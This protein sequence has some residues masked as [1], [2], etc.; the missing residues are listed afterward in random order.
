MAFDSYGVLH[1]VWVDEGLQEEHVLYHISFDG[2]SWTATTAITSHTILSQSPSIAADDLGRIH[3]VWRAYGA[4]W[5]IY[6]TMFDGVSWSEKVQLTDLSGSPLR[7]SMASDD[8]NHLHLAWS[9][10][11]DTDGEIYYKRFNGS[12]WGT[13]TRLTIS[14][15]ASENPSVTVGSDGDIHIFWDDDRSGSF[16]IYH[17]VFD[18]NTWSADQLLVPAITKAEGPSATAGSDGNLHVVWYDGPENN[19]EVFYLEYDGVS[20]G[21]DERISNASGISVNPKVALD[22]FG[23]PQVVW[24]DKRDDNHEIY[25]RSR[26]I[27]PKPEL[28]S[29]APDS[30]MAFSLVEITD[31]AGTGFYGQ[32]RVWL[33]MGGETSI[34]ASNEVIQS[35]ASI[36]CDF[37]LWRSA[38]GDWDVVVENLDLQGDTL[39]ASFRVVP[40]PPGEV[41][42]IVPDAA[43]TYHHVHFAN[44]AGDGFSAEAEVWLRMAGEADID[45]INVLVQSPVRISCD[46]DLMGASPGD[47][48]VVVRNPETMGV[49][50][51]GFRVLP[52]LWDDDLRLT[53]DDAESSTS[54]SNARC[55]AIDGLGN[56]HVVWHDKRDGNKE[57][58]YKKF[59]GNSWSADLRLTDADDHSAYPAIAVDGNNHLHIVW[60]DLRDG[61]FEIYYKKFDGASWGADQRLT[62]AV[63]ESR[64][65]SIAVH[66]HN[67][68]YVAWSDKR[69]S[70]GSR[71][72]YFRQHDGSSWLPELDWELTGPGAWVPAISVDS[73]DQAHI[74]WYKDYGSYTEIHYHRFDGISL[75]G[76]E[77][78]AEG[79]CTYDPTIATDCSNRVHVAWHEK[80]DVDDYGIYYRRFDGLF[81]EPEERVAG[82]CVY[83]YTS[84]I[85]VDN[86]DHI[87]LVWTD[88]RDGNREMCYGFS[89][90][91]GWT[92]DLRLTKA[93]YGSKD[94]SLA[95][96]D[97]GAIHIVWRD[98]RNGNYEIYYKTRV[99]GDMSGTGKRLPDPDSL[100]RLRVVPN[101]VQASTQ[102]E[103]SLGFKTRPVL[104][105]YDVTG[106]LVRRIEVGEREHGPQQISWD[107]TASS[108]KR[109]APGIYLV[110]ISTAKHK[111]S[112]KV[113]VLR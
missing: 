113:I 3:V 8:S 87:H 33:E 23:R 93:E 75:S 71:R 25:W 26:A 41:T 7:A 12:A 22:V 61:D 50:P 15:G 32:V 84:S 100:R 29:I 62:N 96:G 111:A 54:R 44:I 24:Q 13:D 10:L 16:D 97:D 37:D 17:K 88:F 43:Q 53:D 46:F 31:L 51:G 36:T 80:R 101:P 56:L 105:V 30:G 42:A 49:L 47:W 106:R 107:G 94:P 60:E 76:A 66:G 99:P 63:G 52:S 38:E 11:R 9:D 6:H 72:I 112:T 98:Y 28:N 86:N 70:Q 95:V 20:W 57:I 92:D 64:Y 48:D 78:L 21:T 45:A 110:E 35:D 67:G 69:G 2:I 65:P 59:D 27:L 109:V 104:S 68:L 89:V 103:F 19:E 102:I 5:C 39:F 73:S 81:W 4:G 1:V 58:Y 82:S 91:T 85:A 14:P 108:G 74:V 90:G 79:F 18:G 77:V 55:I 34:Q 40:L 83:S